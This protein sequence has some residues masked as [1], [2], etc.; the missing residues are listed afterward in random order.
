MVELENEALK[1]FTVKPIRFY[2]RFVD[3]TVAAL[4]KAQIASFYNHLNNKSKYI[5]FTMEAYNEEKGIPF[6]DTL[7]RVKDDD[8]IQTNVYRKPT[9]SD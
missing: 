9:H 2:Y 4:K 5:K 3:D 8:L 1:T 7:N 6:L